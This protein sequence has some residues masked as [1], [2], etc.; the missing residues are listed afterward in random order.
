MKH[1][2]R[3]HRNAARLL[4]RVLFVRVRFLCQERNFA[5][6]DIF[7]HFSRAIVIILDQKFFS[8][9]VYT[10]TSRGWYCGSSSMRQI[11]I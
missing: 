4:F 11:R 3:N 6:R 1:G 2:V 7:W 9:K 5:E 8:S 10:P